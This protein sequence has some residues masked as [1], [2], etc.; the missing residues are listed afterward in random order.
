MSKTITSIKHKQT[1]QLNMQEQQHLRKVLDLLT[2]D[3]PAAQLSTLRDRRAKGSG[4]WFLSSKQYEAWYCDTG[5]RLLCPGIPGAGK[6]MIAATIIDHLGTTKEDDIGLAYFFCNYKAQAAQK[7]ASVLASLLKQLVQNRPE[8]GAPIRRLY[9]KKGLESG[10]SDCEALISIL[11]SVCS[12]YTRV[13]IV[14]DAL[15]EFSNDDGQRDRL[16]DALS[17]LQGHGNISFLATSQFVPEI[18]ERFASD[19]I[20]EIQADDSDVARFTSEQILALP[21]KCIKRDAEL[22]RTVQKGIVQS[23]DG[24]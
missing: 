16:L 15:D 20:L 4:H 12:T 7:T 13:R 5:T 21:T 1:L 24:M 10:L 17:D 19:P 14:V 22:S 8:A 9:E 2:M 6:T 23:V 3:N 18:T 11:R